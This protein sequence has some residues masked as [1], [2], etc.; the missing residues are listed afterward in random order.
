MIRFSAYATVAHLALNVTVLALLL[1]A[2]T[3][4]MPCTPEGRLRCP[5]LVV[6]LPTWVGLSAV[7]LIIQSRESPDHLI[8]SEYVTLTTR[9]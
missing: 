5:K 1:V 9:I 2:A 6:A 4:T 7:I 3:P 8:G